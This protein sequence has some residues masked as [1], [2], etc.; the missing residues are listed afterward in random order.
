MTKASIIELHG[1]DN[2]GDI[3][4]FTV[5]DGTAISKGTLCKFATPRTASAA[6]GT[7]EAFAGIAST[8]K[9]ASDGST[10]LGF[11]KKGIFDLQDGGNSGI[12][13]G[14][15]VVMSGADLIRKAVTDE[16]LAG[17]IVGVALEDASD[18]EVI[19]VLVG[20]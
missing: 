8:D 5:A 10:N 3:V 2:S 1:D 17:A 15:Q 13:A 9:E 18:G 11:F 20:Y 6:T 16:S 7:G 14:D 4:R 12:S 19:S